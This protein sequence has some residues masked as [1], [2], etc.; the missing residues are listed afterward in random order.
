MFEYNGTGFYRC[1]FHYDMWA[2]GGLQEPPPPSP[3][4][5]IQTSGDILG[6]IHWWAL[7]SSTCNG[8]VCF[9]PFLTEGTRKNNGKIPIHGYTKFYETANMD[10]SWIVNMKIA[11]EQ[12]EVSDRPSAPRRQGHTPSTAYH[13]LPNVYSMLLQSAAPP[14]GVSQK[15][16]GWCL[17]RHWN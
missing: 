8:C 11:K 5:E 16:W 2:S 17:I 13:H 3:P 1:C 6:T 9:F 4:S 14:G 15:Y 10:T 7:K 12:G